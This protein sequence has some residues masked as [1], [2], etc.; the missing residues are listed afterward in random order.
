MEPLT[1][2]V[3]TGESMVRREAL[4]SLSRLAQRLNLSLP[5]EPLLIALEDPDPQVQRSAARLLAGL[6]DPRAV[7]VLQ[8]WLQE[9]DL[10][11]VWLVAV[12]ARLGD[13]QAV[14]LLQQFRWAEHPPI[15]QGW[16]AKELGK[17]H[18][19]RAVA[20]LRP[21][22]QDSGLWVRIDAAQALAQ[23]ND[24]QVADALIQAV[25]TA[26][27]ASAED[28]A[29]LQQWA[30]EALARWQDSRLEEVIAALLQHPAPQ[31]RR[32]T[33]RALQESEMSWS[34]PYL[35][36]ALANAEPS[37]R[38][39]AAIALGK[40]LPTEALEALVER[41]YD[42]DSYVRSRAAQALGRLGDARAVEPL[43][44]ALADPVHEVQVRTIYALAELQ[45][46]RAREPVRQLTEA[47]DEMVRLSASWALA[48]L[49]ARIVGGQTAGDE[50][51]HG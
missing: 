26:P 1:E 37:V 51:Q 38:A 35:L 11:R 6:D 42:E 17:W 5:T 36:R 24:P 22:L 43:I 46:Q 25:Q 50:E 20:L 41:I 23:R 19:P 44:G 31:A 7:P 14:E 45:D 39:D 30:L 12:L 4:G 27:A 3:R 16:L 15:E 49:E 2:A 8:E 28:A 10:F 47:T 40:R 18:D 33:I 21:L 29:R 34:V 32:V 9:G 13:A 48:Q